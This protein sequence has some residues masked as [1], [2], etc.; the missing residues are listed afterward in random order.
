MKRSYINSIKQISINQFVANFLNNNHHQILESELSSFSLIDSPDLESIAEN[1]ERWTIFKEKYWLF[2]RFLP[3]CDWFECELVFP[4]CV[5]SIEIINEES[6][7]D[8]LPV[9]SRL[10]NTINCETMP[11]EK[12]KVKVDALTNKGIENFINEKHLILIGKYD[13][14]TL[15]L[16]DG[17]HRFLALNQAYKLNR[18]TNIKIKCIVGLSFG[19]CRWLGDSVEWE[20]RPAK[21]NEKRYVLNI[22]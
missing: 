14:N 5:D 18:I 1:K 11:N 19:N 8:K 20:E 7:F 3:H 13:N 6:W 16:I 17:N 10:A 22:W 15:S 12:H 9:Q 2:N 21:S 4:D